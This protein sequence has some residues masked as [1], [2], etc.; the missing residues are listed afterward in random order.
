MNATSRIP[1][2]LTVLKAGMIA[3]GIA[4]AANLVLWGIG[5]LVATLSFPFVA[6]IVSTL[7]LFF[8]GSVFYWLLARFTGARAPMI[9]TI[10]SVAFLVVMAFSP[11]NAM[12]SELM[13][14]GGLF[15]FTSMVVAQVM[16]VVAGALAILR[17]PK[18]A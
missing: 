2:F 4:A 18:A 7:V 9:F 16:H 17:I 1:S 8:L 5:S 11:I 6:V 15:N 10:V 12:T 3:G 13:P 14:G